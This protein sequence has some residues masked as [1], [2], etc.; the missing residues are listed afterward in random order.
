M[1]TKNDYREWTTSATRPQR[2]YVEKAHIITTRFGFVVA[3]VLHFQAHTGREIYYTR[4]SF[5]YND[6]VW[7]RTWTTE[8][9]PRTITTL[10]RTMADEIVVRV[11]P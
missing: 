9:M 8:W 5:I 3:E 2:T 10:A 11:T 4:M 1:I 6:L 7:H